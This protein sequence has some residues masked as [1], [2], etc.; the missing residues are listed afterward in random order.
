M[1]PKTVISVVDDD[2]SIRRA[3]VRMI[4]SV[5][6]DV[7]TFASAEEF[8]AS[9]DLINSA[10]LILDVGLPGISGIDLQERLNSASCHIPI[11][12]LTANVDDRTRE[13]VMKAGAVNCFSKPFSRNALLDAVRAARLRTGPRS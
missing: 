12:F 3:L 1:T 10:C 5:G 11:I 13:R 9:G 8:L 6:L 4:K 7:E 2:E